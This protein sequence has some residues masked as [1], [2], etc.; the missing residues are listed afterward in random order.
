[1]PITQSFV[2]GGAQGSLRRFERW[3]QAMAARGARSC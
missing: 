3:Q 1:V 2:P